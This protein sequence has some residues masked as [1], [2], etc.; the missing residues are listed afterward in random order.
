[1]RTISRSDGKVTIDIVVNG[2]T[3]TKEIDNVERL[4]VQL[5]KNADTAMK[6]VG[7]SLGTNTEAGAK[8]ANKAVDSVEKS[9][10]NLGQTTESSSAKAGAAIGDNFDSGAKEANQATDS[11]TKG[12]AD[13]TATTSTELA[14]TGRIMGESFEAG[15]KD[16]NNANDSVEKSVNQLLSSVESASPRFGQEIGTSFSSGA[17]E[18]SGALD[19]IGKSSSSLLSSIEASASS[20]GNSLD[21]S[22]DSGAK[23]ATNATDSIGKSVAQMVPQVEISATKA[24]KSIA[25]SLEAGAKDGARSISDAVESMKKDLVSVGNEASQVGSKIQAGFVQ[26]E[27]SANKLTSSIGDLSAAMLLSKGAASALAMTKGS[28]DGAFGRIDTLDNFQRTMTRVTGSSTEAQ[29]GMEGVRDAV[30]GTSYTLDGAAQ[31]VQRLVLQNGSLERSTKSYEIWGDAVALYGDGSAETMQNVMD[32]IIQMRAT[33]TVNMAQMDRIVRRGIDP[34]HIY[35]EASG[36][37]IGEVRDAL[38]DGV[39]GAEEFFDTIE[40][41]MREGRGA[42]VSVAGAAREAGNTWAGSFANMATATARGTANIITSVDN[43]FSE[44]RFGSMKENVQGFGKT[45]EDSLNGIARV[46]PPV[47]STIDNLVGGVVDLAQASPEANAAIIGLTGAVVGYMVV[48]RAE[49]YTRAY[50]T[51]IKTLTGAKTAAA[52]VTKTLT[53]AEK[54]HLGAA[55]A[56]KATMAGSAAAMKTYIVVTKALTAAK[57]ALK[58]AFTLVGAGIGAVVAIGAVLFKRWNDNR[59]AAKEFA[60]ELDS[61]KDDLDSLEKST[62]S[63]VSGF[64]AQEKVIASNAERHR[65]LATELQRLSAIENKSAA[66]KKMLAD[67][68]DALNDSVTGLNLSYDEETGALNATTQ[69]IE[70]RIEASR[71]MEEVSR[72]TER[73]QQLSQESAEIETKLAEVAK[74]RARIEWEASASGVDG[75]KAVKESLDGLLEKEAELQG[76]LVEH[77]SEKEGLYESEMAL[78]QEVANT[79]ASANAMMIDSYNGLSVSQKAALDSMNSMYKSLVETSTDAF[80]TIEQ[81]EAISLENMIDNLRKNA[82]AM[83]SWSTNVALL[84]EAGVSDGIIMQLEKMGPAG[85]QQAALLVEQTGAGLEALPEEGRKRIEALNEAMGASMGEAMDSTARIAGEKSE[86]V[87]EKIGMIPEQAETSLQAQFEGRNFSEWGRRVP[88]EFAEGQEEGLNQVKQASEKLADTPAEIIGPKVSEAGYSELGSQVSTNFGSGILDHLEPIE[89]ASK[90]VAEIPGR[91]LGEVITPEQYTESGRNIGTGLVQGINFGISDVEN[92][93]RTMAENANNAFKAAAGINSPSTIYRGFG[94][95][96]TQGAV[97]GIN[98]G[99]NAVVDAVRQMCNRM[100]QEARNSVQNMSLNFDNVVSGAEN[101]LRNLPNVATRNMSAMNSSFQSGA[102]TQQAT[103][104]TLNN[105]IIQTF[106]NTPSQFQNIGRNMM[107]RMNSAI[108]SESSRI[109][110][111]TRNTANRIVQSFNQTPN[112]M[113]AAGRNGMAGLNAGLSAGLGAPVSTASRTRS[114]IVSNFSGLPSQMSGVGQSAM[115]GLNA[116]LN[117]GSGAVMAT[118]KRIANQVTSTIRRALDINSPSRVMAN[119][120]GQWIPKGIASGIEKYAGTAYQAIDNLSAG[121]LRISTP[122][123]ALG[124]SQMGRELAKENVNQ[125]IINRSSTIDMS[126]L[127]QLIESRPVRVESYL[128]GEVVSQEVD[129]S[130]GNRAKRHSYAGGVSFA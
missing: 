33:G 58:M 124:A 123:M 128:N 122:E 40:V 46:I 125:T 92:A 104:R 96:I 15:A 90:E 98:S 53:V 6:N 1:M 21:S 5:G 64:E 110:T 70:K 55:A 49:L 8:T 4:F 72:L 129:R 77:Q 85:A 17:K 99:S 103:M 51:S 114:A 10:S 16:A 50:I 78:R 107:S 119:D 105:N 81:N 111:T 2:K 41:A 25:S 61:L 52:A 47:V 102:Q 27:P 73:Q 30:V 42:V 65:S 93:T 86:D 7:N 34:W 31:T 19:G 37:S 59:K 84:A 20:A 91:I 22:F 29:A 83:Q 62:E 11:I 120:V 12:V 32:A 18:A 94:E 69:E 13:L 109:L 76:K 115:S 117:A 100:E 82:E 35:A 68:V 23:Q 79:T 38:K 24:G 89:S 116:G 113:Q 28:L 108:S 45:F 75:K 44:T 112:Q 43:A 9:V 60:S 106:S 36:M 87:A 97:Q 66:D 57:I 54:S 71:G 56:S 26:P 3:I 48:K 39:I 74:E 130:I 88:E 14:K 127:A 80:Q 101:S 118:A 95:N 67:T 121:M 63:S 126:A